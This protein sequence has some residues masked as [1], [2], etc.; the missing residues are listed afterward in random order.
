ML[1]NNIYDGDIYD[2]AGDDVDIDD[3]DDDGDDNDC[4]INDENDESHDKKLLI[5]HLNH[6]CL[7][8]NPPSPPHSLIIIKPA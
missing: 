8:L 3:D 6:M 1:Q 2:H 5:C 4:K 7:F